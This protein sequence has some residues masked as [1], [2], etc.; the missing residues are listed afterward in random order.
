M[1]RARDKSAIQ[2][3]NQPWP[4]YYLKLWVQNVVVVVMFY[5]LNNVFAYQLVIDYEIFHC[6]PEYLLSILRSPDFV[7]AESL[8]RSLPVGRVAEICFVLFH[9]IFSP[10]IPVQPCWKIREK[11]QQGITVL[12]TIGVQFCK[13]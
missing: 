13:H 8:E 4:K 3:I 9:S 6:C 1:K 5:A 2:G 11:V 12:S 10:L 7:S